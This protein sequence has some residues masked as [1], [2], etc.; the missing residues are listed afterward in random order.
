MTEKSSASMAER[1][2]ILLY[3]CSIII[4]Y[5]LLLVDLIHNYVADFTINQ[6]A[7]IIYVFITGITALAVSWIFLTEKA[8]PF[9]N[10][11]FLFFYELAS[12]AVF[13]FLVKSAPLYFTIPAAGIEWL[14]TVK[15]EKTF[16]AHDAFMN[17]V[18]GKSGPELYRL[19]HEQN[20]LVSDFTVDGK[21]S[22]FN[23]GIAVFIML[24]I[25]LAEYFAGFA[26]SPCT[27]VFLI[28]CII[29]LLLMLIL[30]ST[31]SQE[32]YF[33]GIG[34]NTVFN[35]R[36]S[37]IR[38]SLGFCLLSLLA[39]FILSP[40][41]AILKPSYFSWILDLF[42]RMGPKDVEATSAAVAE[43]AAE[44]FDMGGGFALPAD[45]G[46][47]PITQTI[48]LIL[49]IVMISGITGGFLFFFFGPFFSA[50]WKNF[51]KNGKLKAYLANIKA[52]F[53]N[54]LKTLFTRR[55]HISANY[56]RAATEAFRDRMGDFLKASGKTKEK[57]K[58]IDRLTDRFLDI[59]RWG[60]EHEVHYGKHLAPA[61]YTGM[62]SARFPERTTSAEE[63][64]QLFEKAL[65]SK[66]LLTSDEEKR[67]LEA[68]KELTR[69][70][71]V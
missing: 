63:A 38:T 11:K 61:E 34:M 9:A 29:S 20:W 53:R 4:T 7:F 62:I 40:G 22:I 58:E 2:L 31:Y 56:A 14:I 39:A 65:Y 27:I 33:A 47:H 41:M 59:I 19:L 16:T 25:F 71:E 18:E 5:I 28:V 24:V 32:T 13:I 12:V 52:G 35:L 60:E 21:P 45:D 54:L 30:F 37:L 23:T 64:G 1:V 55:K 51:W 17:A 42:R 66:E 70:T 26:F 8:G 36:G 69:S 15:L 68:A 50:K 67:F 3:S 48:L 6:A 43:Y 46:D 44:S 10:V 57:R 49:K